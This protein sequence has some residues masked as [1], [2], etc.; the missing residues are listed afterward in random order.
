MKDI[1]TINECIICEKVAKQGCPYRYYPYNTA[2]IEYKDIE[3][4]CSHIVLSKK[5]R[6]EKWKRL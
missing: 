5:S 1:D 2:K 3:C 4:K 6:E